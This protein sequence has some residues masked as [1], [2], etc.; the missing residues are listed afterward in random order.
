MFPFLNPML[1]P[2]QEPDPEPA[3]A[4]DRA[5]N[6]SAETAELMS[7]G[8]DYISDLNTVDPLLAQ[9]NQA[10]ASKAQRVAMLEEADKQLEQQISMDERILKAKTS[11]HGR[12]AKHKLF[13]ANNQVALQGI[14]QEHL[15]SMTGVDQAAQVQ[16][17]KYN[18]IAAARMAIVSRMRG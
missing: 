14:N 13:L 9:A 18:G 2:K 17:S 16:E 11:M 8:A 10:I 6:F 5:K 1:P 12:I 15:L 4:I 3:S 7:M